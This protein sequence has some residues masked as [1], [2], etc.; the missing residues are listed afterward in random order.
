M[1]SMALEVGCDWKVWGYCV[2]LFTGRAGPE[3]SSH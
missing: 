3:S 1:V 2:G